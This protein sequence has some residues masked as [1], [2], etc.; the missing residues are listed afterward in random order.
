M[1]AVY[2]RESILTTPPLLLLA[3]N[4]DQ[5]LI[6]LIEIYVWKEKTLWKFR[7][8]ETIQSFT[9]LLLEVIENFESTLLLNL[10]STW[11]LTFMLVI[12]LT[13]DLPVRRGL[14]YLCHV[15]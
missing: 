15:I 4:R 9:E 12:D 8:L 14:M 1:R 3:N 10:D 13:L 6:T 2:P 5:L 7:K 11:K